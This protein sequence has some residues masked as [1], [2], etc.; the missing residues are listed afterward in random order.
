M[1]RLTIAI[2]AAWILMLASPVSAYVW[3]CHTPN[4]DVWT[5]QPPQS[6]DCEEF[7]GTFNPNSAP[8]AA[9]RAQSAPPVQYP[10][11]QYA[12][13]PPPVQYAQPQYAPP[14]PPVY[15]YPYPAPYPVPYPSPV[16]YPY[17]PYA[18]RYYGG[19]PGIYLGLPFLGF[20][21]R[22]GGHGGHFGG[23]HVGGHRWR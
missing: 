8:Q 9:P 2:L 5:G 11:P 21:F 12:P 17:Y 20:D 3:R 19:G 18:P 15:A 4:G 7:D 1:S 6:G 10:Q 14:A 23:G 13:A 16:P 22:F